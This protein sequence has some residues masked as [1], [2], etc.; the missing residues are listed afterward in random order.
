[1]R[2]NQTEG[3]PVV[4]L[5]ETWANSNIGKVRTWVEPDDK[6]KGGTKGGFR[7]PSG[8]GSRL[9]VLHAGSE[10]DWVDGADLVF[11]SKKTTGDYH[12]EMN[13]TTFE[14]WFHDKLIPNIQPNSLIVM[15][16]A[17]YHSRRLESIPTKNTRKAEMQNW[18]TAHSIA[19]PERTIKRELLAL[20]HSSNPQAKYAIDEMA[21]AAGHEVVRIPPYHC[22]FNPIELCWSQVKGYIKE[23]N[24]KFTL[25]AVK[26]L[27]YEGFKKVTP[28][29]WKKNVKHIRK[30]V[31]NYFWEADN[32]QDQWIN[33]FCIQVDSDEESRESEGE[34]NVSNSS[35]DE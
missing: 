21:K 34:S 10:N 33:E 12:D 11:Q 13:A 20:I 28:I 3:R 9:I 27:T 19:Y 18:L 35:D 5:D 15:D 1:M 22:E 6:V 4:Y 24:K 2:R 23:H 25:T 26:E 16:N 17:S 8:K 31:E 29:E 7:K 32:L 30:K 14:E